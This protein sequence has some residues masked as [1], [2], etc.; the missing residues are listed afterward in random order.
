MR[1][2]VLIAFL[3]LTCAIP[4]GSFAETESR[5]I[6]SCNEKALGEISSRN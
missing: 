2:R 6:P 4:Q 1:G 3:L 5:A